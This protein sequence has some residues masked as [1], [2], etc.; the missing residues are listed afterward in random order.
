MLWVGL[1][2]S[3]HAEQ[4]ASP[5]QF[6]IETANN[7]MDAFN[8]A[9]IAFEKRDWASAIS[10]MEKV[11]SIC[12]A[13]PDKKA[14]ESQKPRLEPVYYTI[15][16]A[17]FNLP[18]YAKAISAFERFVTEYPKSER[19]PFARLAIARAAFMSKDFEKAAQLF[20]EM[21]KFPSMRE[22]SLTIQA[23]C[24]KETGKT[25]E[26]IAVIEKLI[27][28][29]ITNSGRAGAALLLAK[30]RSDAGELD[31]LAILLGQLTASRQFVENLVELNA[32]IVGLGD[33]QS[34]KE[35]FEKASRTYLHVM[36]PDEVKAYQKQ[37]IESLERRIAAN[38][39]A[40]ARNPQGDVTM[41]SQN[42]ELQTVL[43]Q[44]K[45]L[46]GEFEKLPDYMP[47]LL[48]RSSRCWYGRHL[49]WESILVNDRLIQL[50]PKASKEK[51]AALY[52]NVLGY[53][54]LMRVKSC[55]KACEL[56]LKEFPQGDNS[57]TVAYVQG[58]V[59]MQSG[60]IKGAATLF[61]T[62]VDTY[63]NSSFIDQM[64]LML[65]SAHFNLGELD[66]ALTTYNRYISKFPKGG[67][68]EE[69]CYRA[70]IIPVFQGKYEEAWPILEGFLKN[71][72]TSQFTEDA[73]Y[74]LMIC[75]YA[76]NLYDDVLADVAKWQKDHP[77][78][79]MAPEVL[80]LQGDCLAAQLK[81]KEAAE[82]YMAASK[83]AATDE[84]LNYSL[85]EASKLLQ[86]LGDF[87]QLSKLWEDFV[88][89]SPDHPSV[90]AG[91]YW[92][93][94]AKTREG[95]VDEAKAIAVTQL[96]RCLNNYKNESVEMLLQQ[97]AQL[98]WKRPRPLAPP[99]APEP[100]PVLDKD[101][102]AVPPPGAPAPPPLPP[103]DAMAEL[104]KQIGPLA[105]IADASGKARLSFVRIELLKL[106]KKQEEAD[107]LMR[108][109]AASR[110]EILSPQ[111]LALSGDF[112]Q[113]QKD[114]SG[115][116]V[117]Y[118]Y[119][120]ENFLKSA[121]LDYAYSGLGE[122]ALAKGDFKTALQLYTLAVDEY[123]GGKVKES[124][125]GLGIAMMENGRYP[126]AKKIFEQVAGTREWRGEATAKSVFYL[127]M[128]EE[129]QEHLAEA[130]AQYQRV[131]VAYQK[132]IPW[133]EKAY[134][135]A[136]QCFDRLG[137]RSEA[138]AHLKEVINNEKLGYEVKL[139]ARELMTK[140]G[141]T[142]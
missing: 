109:I 128:V 40:A 67:A 37:R 106:L 63:P 2:V 86:K 92:I 99:P 57:S 118:Q 95:K 25:A 68:I 98:C 38:K 110:P 117:F 133:V 76:A 125:L 88:E 75:K 104:E 18:D 141:E 107:A 22:Q 137:K 120:K 130:V 142:P 49:L 5:G 20:A 6:D 129:R 10:R 89:R 112:L 66:E 7:M 113:H 52:G 80:S 74:R 59:T 84:V 90:V 82:A 71:Y 41:L 27:A 50:Y 73:E 100:A 72:P 65:A 126:E 36:P 44:A 69:A 62:L 34:A 108:E 85:N 42:A 83:N 124:T 103:W 132:Y 79:I 45:S 33:A 35:Q 97:L 134:I 87:E 122:M 114:D 81:T 56:Y 121:W 91:I 60:D 70:A 139:E 28:D 102:K 13:Y 61:G 116:S 43:E 3:V 39:A 15:G 131:F 26:M 135:K 4:A 12:E 17:A 24:F 93:G 101:G 54:D 58:A 127:G 119:L 51:E 96:K 47:G 16:A 9:I 1:P 55:Q 30:A 8:D 78:G 19:V 11:I 14:V 31:K 77:V 123:A 46:L 111:L 140:W 29:G 138:V 136:A 53:A 94:K 21:E 32:L 105:A 23:Q 64:Y 115:A 48:L